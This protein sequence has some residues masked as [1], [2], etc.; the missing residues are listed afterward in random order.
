[1]VGL[2]QL[3]SSRGG[4]LADPCPTC[5]FFFVGDSPQTPSVFSNWPWVLRVPTFG[6]LLTPLPLL[7]IP[8]F[9]TLF[10]G[11]RAGV[12]FVSLVTQRTDMTFLPAISIFSERRCLCGRST[13]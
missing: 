8:Y 12:W 10:A 11:Q 2:V 4:D 13:C 6:W 5:L 1:M 3:F 7:G 9:A